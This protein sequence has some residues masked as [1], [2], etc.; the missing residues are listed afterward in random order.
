M[1]INIKSLI[2]LFINNE[3]EVEKFGEWAFG[4]DYKDTIGLINFMKNWNILHGE[5]LMLDLR[6]R[7]KEDMSRMIELWNIHKNIDN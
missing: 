2:E 6:G 7:P 3:D 4:K 5:L 1:S